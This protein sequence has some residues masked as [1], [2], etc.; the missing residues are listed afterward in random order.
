MK[1]VRRKV[2]LVQRY[3]AYCTSTY[4]SSRYTRTYVLRVITVARTRCFIRQ[5]RILYKVDTNSDKKSKKNRKWVLETRSR[6][7]NQSKT[8]RGS[9]YH[10]SRFFSWIQKNRKQ[11][12]R[13]WNQ[14]RK[15]VKTKRD[16]RSHT[17]FKTRTKKKKSKNGFW[18]L[19]TESTI[20]QK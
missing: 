8:R 12:F 4:P 14:N 7:D 20:R 15:S 2:L 17:N 13:S 16:S 6:I 5:A 1:N 3:V 18:K 19:E 10:T 11:D 9:R